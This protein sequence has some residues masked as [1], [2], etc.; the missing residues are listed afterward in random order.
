MIPAE[1]AQSNLT[2]EKDGNQRVR[3]TAIEN[4]TKQSA[5]GEREPGVEG[6]A[7]HNADPLQIQQEIKFLKGYSHLPV[8]NYISTAGTITLK[9]IISLHFHCPVLYSAKITAMKCQA[10]DIF[11]IKLQF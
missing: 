11:R 4:T 6:A 8:C 9:L 10:L 2:A 5:A 1:D 7:Q 3:N